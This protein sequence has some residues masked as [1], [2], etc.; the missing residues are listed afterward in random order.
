VL[1]WQPQKNTQHSN[2]YMD[3]S[4]FLSLLSL[5]ALTQIDIWTSLSFF[6]LLLLSLEALFGRQ[7]RIEM[8]FRKH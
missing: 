5:E 1:S 6:S 8:L 7:L 3:V 2:K 4:V